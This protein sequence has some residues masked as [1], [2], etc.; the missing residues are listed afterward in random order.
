MSWASSL[1]IWGT[2]RDTAP[3][4]RRFDPASSAE[5]PRPQRVVGTAVPFPPA[6]RCALVTASLDE[7]RRRRSHPGPDARSELLAHPGL[8]LG[9][10]AVGVEAGDVESERLGPAPQ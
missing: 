1:C 8:D 9:V 5:Q 4:S 6:S 10:A 7:E 3:A 2:G